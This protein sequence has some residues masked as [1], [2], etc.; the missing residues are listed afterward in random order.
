[1]QK[2]KRSA[3]SVAAAM[4]LIGLCFL[5][6]ASPAAGAEKF[7]IVVFGGTPG[8]IST[9]ITAARLGNTVALLE[10]HNHLGGMA[11]SGLGKTD[12]ET[13]EAIGGLFKEF[14]ARV[15]KYYVGKYGADSENV[16]LCR[17]GY[18]YEPSVAEK[19]FDEMV[20]AE[21][22]IRVFRNHRLDRVSR[23][24]TRVVS[25][26][27]TD[28]KTESPTEFEGK[29]FVDATYEGDL[30]AFAGARYRLGRESR[31]E[32][33]ELHAGVVYQDPKTRT[34]LA[35]TTGEGDRRLQ[36]YT[37]RLCLTTDPA[38]SRKMTSAPPDY[39]RSRYAGYID[40]WKAGRLGNAQPAM[41]GVTNAVRTGGG[42]TLRAFTIAPLPNHKTDCNMFPRVLAY[43][44][45]ELNYDYPE[46]GEK[47]RT[48]ITTRIRN[49][50]KGLLY[51]LQNDSEVPQEHRKLANQFHFPKDE[52]ADNDYFPWQL[53]VREARRIVG[54][55]T[56]TENDMILAPGLDRTRI[57]ADSITAG[58]FPID[59]MPVRGPEKGQDVI[60]EGYLLML[61]NITRPYQIPYRIIVPEAVDSLLVPVAA[62]TT[63]VA[64]SSVRLEPTWMALGQAAAVAAHLAI[65]TNRQPRQ[66]TA[67]E[68][69]RILLRQKQVLTYFTD[70]DL[71][72]PAFEAMQFLG[73]RGFFT[74][75]ESRPKETLSQAAAARWMGLALKAGGMDIQVNAGSS[76]S[77]MDLKTLAMLGIADRAADGRTLQAD[78]PLS[79]ADFKKWLAATGVVLGAW[80]RSGD[81]SG[82]EALWKAEGLAANG[83]LSRGE[84][85]RAIYRLLEKTGH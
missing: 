52:F 23:S 59:S 19:I 5:A 57:Q 84:F 33:N 47:R 48:E 72:D 83:E 7:D 6:A 62:S 38:N 34:F 35:G 20:A 79:R 24:G 50:T 25:L 81:V 56:L 45:V 80:Q 3:S 26:T 49:V 4:W 32:F 51:F 28:R 11:A 39:D 54:M 27:A 16:R 82:T 44:F 75:Y 1:M 64:F 70:L 2:V 69:Q 71:K 40:D 63:H 14:I 46:A 65:E 58:E 8:G 41:E 67:H 36:A 15:Y 43:P 9:A 17:G 85:C 10:Y 77:S 66:L 13:P 76:P 42:T 18:Y 21:S 61:N 31:S 60:L 74:S 68:L 73:A 37:F 55:Y 22:R 12:I 53:Y 29:M 30:A 78:A